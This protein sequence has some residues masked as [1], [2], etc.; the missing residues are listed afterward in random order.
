[1]LVNGWPQPTADFL[2]Y[3]TRP[4]PSA[5]SPVPHVSSQKGVLWLTQ[6]LTQEATAGQYLLLSDLPSLDIVSSAV[7]ADK[8]KNPSAEG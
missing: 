3:Q 2:S 7:Q 8:K 4:A 1:M 6:P 5:S